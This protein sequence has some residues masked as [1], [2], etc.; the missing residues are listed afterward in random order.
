MM[1]PDPLRRPEVDTLLAT[2]R[3]QKI[4]AQRKALSPFSHVVNILIALSKPYS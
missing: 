1:D 2:N 4:L 3:I